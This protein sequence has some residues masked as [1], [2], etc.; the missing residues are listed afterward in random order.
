MSLILGEIAHLFGQSRTIRKEVIMFSKDEVI[1]CSQCGCELEDEIWASHYAYEWDS[2][3]ILCGD[4][5]CWAGW[6]QDNTFSH[7]IE[8]DEDE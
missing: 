7:N 8:R 1:Q 4:G 6:M 5:D 2:C 3:N